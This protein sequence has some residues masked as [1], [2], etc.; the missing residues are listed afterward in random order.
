[1]TRNKGD[2]LIAFLWLICGYLCWMAG[3]YLFIWGTSNLVEP[4]SRYIRLKFHLNFSLVSI[5]F[6]IL[7]ITDFIIIFPIA[8]L[9][10]RAIGK[11]KIWFFVFIVG[12]V[13]PPLYGTIGGNIEY[14]LHY[15][16]LPSEAKIVLMRILL[17]TIMAYLFITP[18]VGWLGITLGNRYRARKAA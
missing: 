17:K 8:F 18:L 1:M 12:V 16:T 11:R 13:A 5:G 3:D 6:I 4:T 10:S 2:Y 14:V 15:D 9:L 7:L